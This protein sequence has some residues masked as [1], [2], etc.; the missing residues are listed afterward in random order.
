[1]DK[2]SANLSRRTVDGEG[3]DRGQVTEA[4]EGLS[5]VVHRPPSARASSL[6]GQGASG[7]VD[8]P[9]DEPIVARG[10][11][12]DA[13]PAGIPGQVTTP[14]RCMLDWRR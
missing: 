2:E 1:M 7:A 9:Y 3:R 5:S 10:R 12:L 14:P 13:A 6:H 11:D 4:W 8:P